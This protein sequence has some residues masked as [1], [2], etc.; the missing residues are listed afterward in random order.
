MSEKLELKQEL[1]KLNKREKKF[2][3]KNLVDGKIKLKVYEKIPESLE[4]MLNKAFTKAFEIIF[5]KATPIIEKSFDKEKINLEFEIRKFIL[6][7]KENKT[8]IKKLDREPKKN[9]VINN[10]LATSVGTG[11]GI[12]GLGIPDIP[13]FVATILRGI[14]QIAL[15]YGFEYKDEKE[16]IYILRLIRIAL[17]KSSDEKKKYNDELINENS[18]NTQIQDEIK[19]TV[20]V[21]TNA[22]LIEKFVQGIPIVGVI[23]GVVNNAIYRKIS[24]F[25]M[26]KY[27]KRYIINK[28]NKS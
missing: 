9:N 4:E 20:N 3:N 28:I 24:N 23:G 21:M 15:S 11:M 26:I 6:D 13:I 27:K 14:Y 16:R 12:L 5:N 8:N 10:I 7:Y 22:L 18:Y 19:I 1:N 17:A 25:C 2:L